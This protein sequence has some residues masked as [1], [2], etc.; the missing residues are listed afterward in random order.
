MTTDPKL[1]I[2]GLDCADPVL[3]FDKWLDEL[4]NIKSIVERG[5][6]GPLESTIPAITVPAWMCM[7]T[8]QDPGQLGFY[9]FRN[10]RD[11]SYDGLFFA[12]SRAVRVDAAWDALGRA[13]KQVIVVGV[14]PSYPPKPVNGHLISC[15]LTPDADSEFTYP[16]SLKAEIIK[17][18]GEY[19]IDVGDFRTDDKAYLLE[20]VW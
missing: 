11:H 14:P 7:M 17:E 19:I 5:T 2:I 16:A 3:V 20:Q 15:F 12:N 13:G 8:S 4:P 6:W 9:G 10:R 18:F 1:A